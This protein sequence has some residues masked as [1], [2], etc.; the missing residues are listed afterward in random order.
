MDGLVKILE[1]K[2]EENEFSFKNLFV[3]LTTA[4]AITWI[5]IIGVVVYANML[6]NGFVWDDLTF[7]I[8]TP[9]IHNFDILHLFQKNIFND[10]GYYRPI[11]AVY[12]S[13]LWNLFGNMSFF[14]HFFQMALHIVSACL[15]FIFLKKF[16]HNTLSFFLVFIFI[17]HPIQVESVAYIGAT[18]SE[19]L[20]IFGMLAFLLSTK[21]KLF[22]KQLI[23]IALFS[24][25]SILTKET[26]FLFIPLILFY[27]FLFKN[28]KE[29]LRLL[30]YMVL[31]FIIY[32]LIRLIFANVPFQN[33]ES[34][35]IGMAPLYERLFNIPI[36]FF[37]YLKTFFFP[38][39][40]GVNQR[41]YITEINF[42]NFYLP[43]IIDVLFF[44]ALGYVG[45]L[46]FKRNQQM[47]RQFIFFFAWFFFGMGMLM[48]I[49]PLDMTVADRWFYFP[50]VGLLGM[51]GL[52]ASLITMQTNMQRKMR[53]FGIL[54]LSIILVLLSARTIIRNSNWISPIVLYTHDINVSDNF[55]IENSLG[56]AYTA[57]GDHKQA[58]HHYIK[59]VEFTPL[60]VNLYNLGYTYQQLGN[61]KM[62]LKYYLQVLE[63]KDI[64]TA[65][66]L[67][68]FQQ[69][70][71]ILVYIQNEPKIGK[72]YI[73]QGLREFP[74]DGSLWAL[75]AVSEYKLQ[76][77]SSALSAARNAKMFLPNNSTNSLYLKI[78]N[79]EPLQIKN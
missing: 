51:L 40:L 48:Q 8:I 29:T 34:T 68:S 56:S 66:K 4:K 73:V 6:F 2:K 13:I 43:F 49:Y 25:L 35:S 36:I 17:I 10:G 44:I 60:P 54:A 58:L 72:P 50:I 41:W 46:C 55:D 61:N 69:I 11:P 64:R 32:S 78:L 71:N 7:I 53:I 3:P 37:Y 30:P 76:D 27:Q 16:F 62:A 22:V 28:K 63:Y 14:Y 20:F 39:A 77:Y 59:S 70:G 33:N 79:K 21:Q 42:T 74:Y 15:L 9:D 57:I 23:I 18:Q 45:Y 47:F 75:L 67:Y 52:I 38:A 12:F 24:L 26:S 1:T 65:P 19:L 5:V 31:V